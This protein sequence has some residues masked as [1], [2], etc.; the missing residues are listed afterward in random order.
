[1]VFNSG[2]WHSAHHLQPA[3]SF[4]SYLLILRSSVTSRLHLSCFLRR[5][6]QSNSERLFFKRIFI[7][8]FNFIENWSRR[9]V[10]SYYGGIF[11]DPLR[12]PLLKLNRLRL[13]H[14]HARDRIR[15]RAIDDLKRQTRLSK[16]EKKKEEEREREKYRD[17]TGCTESNSKAKG[18]STLAYKPLNIVAYRN[19]SA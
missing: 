13:F 17:G 9:I 10:R 18:I 5:Y 2:W 16:I 19:F 4:L 15:T 12:G 1:M 11:F 14:C 7:V 8:A 6:F 3:L